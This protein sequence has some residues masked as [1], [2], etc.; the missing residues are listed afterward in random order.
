VNHGNETGGIRRADDGARW[1]IPPWPVGLP[2]TEVVLHFIHHNR[3]K[4][5][6]ADELAYHEGF[7]HA[8]EAATKS[9]LRDQCDWT[10]YESLRECTARCVEQ[11]R[12]R[13]KAE[14]EAAD[15]KAAK[16]AA[17]SKPRRRTALGQVS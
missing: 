11:Y 13:L 15:N 12:E 14:R 8:I 7:L 1:L 17:A 16:R 6:T 5:G 9:G 2:V 3:D 4:L 10:W